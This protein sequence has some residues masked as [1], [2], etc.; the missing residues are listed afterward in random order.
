MEVGATLPADPQPAELM[1][2]GDSALYRPPLATQ[3][4]AVQDATAGDQRTDA[5]P[6]DQA[7]ILVVVIAPISKQ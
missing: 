5:T 4:R 1:Q 2:P 6:A 3:P 7:A